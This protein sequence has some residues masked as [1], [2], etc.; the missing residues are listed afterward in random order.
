MAIFDDITGY[1]DKSWGPWPSLANLNWWK[2]M[3]WNSRGLTH[4]AAFRHEQSIWRQ[5]QWMSL[6]ELICRTCWARRS[7][8][9]I[10]T[11]LWPKVESLIL[12]YLYYSRFT[13]II[14]ASA[15]Y[16]RYWLPTRPNTVLTVVFHP[17][18]WYCLRNWC[19]VYG[20]LI[21]ST[22]F[23]ALSS[24]YRYYL[25]TNFMSHRYKNAHHSVTMLLS[26]NLLGV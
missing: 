24:L 13:E 7:F 21:E 18:S 20:T 22:L 15:A 19:G 10:T 1:N 5:R 16:S 2:W 26:S 23:S 9:A 3:L 6:R 4:A 11:L 17:P 14:L 8:M 12:V 25:C